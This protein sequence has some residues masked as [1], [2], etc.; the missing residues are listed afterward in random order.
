[1]ASGIKWSKGFTLEVWVKVTQRVPV[2]FRVVEKPG[3]PLIA[4]LSAKVTV[5]TKPE[6]R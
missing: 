3:F 1:M 2:R 5:D 6:G 4:G